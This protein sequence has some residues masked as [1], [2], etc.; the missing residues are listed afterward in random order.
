MKLSSNLR[1]G[2]IIC[3][4]AT[5]SSLKG[6]D[7]PPLPAD[8]PFAEYRNMVVFTAENTF[9]QYENFNRMLYLILQGIAVTLSALVPILLNAQAFNNKKK[10]NVVTI[11]SILVAL[12]VGLTT[13]INPKEQSIVYGLAKIKLRNNN[14]E[15]ETRKGVYEK[16]DSAADRENT[17]RYISEGIMSNASRGIIDALPDSFSGK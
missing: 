2:L 7:P 15:F 3:L 1:I 10:K 12:S 5:V 16:L 6:G 14:V 8:M 17:Y 13:V 9:Q 11:L 4:S